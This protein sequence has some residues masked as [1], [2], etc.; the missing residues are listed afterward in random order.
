LCLTAS[1]ESEN[2]ARREKTMDLL[3]RRKYPEVAEVLVDGRPVVVA[4]RISER[5]RSY[6]L[7]IPNA[8]PP[9]LTVPMR[10]R[11]REAESFLKRQS[12]WLE[13]RLKRKPQAVAFAAGEVIPVR[14]VDHAIVATG[15]I[16]GR[17]EVVEGDDGFELHVP[18]ERAHRARRLADWLK[19]EAQIDLEKR[20]ARHARRLG[21]TVKSVKLRSPTSRWGSCSTSGRLNFNWRLILAPPYV[22]D[23]VAA[24]EVAHLVEMNHSPAFWRTV[25]QTLPNMERG[26][27][28][29]KAHG[30]QLMVY[31][32]DS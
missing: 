13:A 22:L 31:G 24:H 16:R 2:L 28:W 14:G 19:A 20:V 8:G 10:G 11:W 7:S 23:Y 4:V 17:V 6:R 15:R 32:L 9:V 30:R 1:V 29:L 26:R 5:A 18:G 21:V 12:A 25:E 27:A 3:F